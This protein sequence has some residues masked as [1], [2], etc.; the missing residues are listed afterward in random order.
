MSKQTKQTFLYGAT[1]LMAS[2]IVVKLI[3]YIFKIPLSNI[4]QE[5]GMSYFTAA[6]Q[7]FNTVYA[8]TV[9]GLSAAVARMVAET[10]SKGRYRDA[11][12]ILKISNVIFFILGILGMLITLFSAKGIS[13]F[14]KIPNSY[15][16]I[17][18]LSPALFF[19]CAMASYRGYYEGLSNMI[20][21]AITQIV[22]VVVKLIA[23]LGFS[24][25][26]IAIGK[27]QYLQNGT[28]F[29]MVIDNEENLMSALLPYASAGAVLGVTISTLIGFIYIFIRYKMKGDYITKQ[30]LMESPKAMNTN[31]LFLRLVKI[32]IPVT[33][34]AVVIQLS[35]FIDSITISNRLAYA[36]SKDPEYF[37]NLY[38]HLITDDTPMNVFLYGCF[39]V[40]ISIFNLV[41]AFTNIFG[42]SALPNVTAAWTT[43]NKE[44]I[45]T[46]IES[47]IRVTMLIA[48][49]IGFGI[50]A[51]S[52]GILKLLYPNLQGVLTVGP[53]L[54]STLGFGA[55]LL[56]LVTPMNAIMQGIG[57]V[58][59][60][61]KFMFVGAIL[62]LVLN[63]ILIGIPKIN[64]IGS[65]ISTF[66]C[67]GVILALYINTL[68]KNIRINLNYT[69]IFLKPA[70]CGLFCGISAFFSNKA[71]TFMKKDSIITLLSIMVG[72]LV[73]MVSLIALNAIAEDDVLMLPK[74]NK[75]L[76]LF[77]KFRIIR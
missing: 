18:M 5:T 59:L 42:K 76:K 7:L 54:L 68:R 74:G 66:V 12:K 73:Y 43:K 3:G 4:L 39:G 46:N 8:L 27:Q 58:D 71:L 53:A 31:V 21:T 40:V 28:A 25:L 22:E 57:K 51:L 11:R 35:A 13:S 33:L 26:I 9:T 55:I 67:Y 17:V 36:Y 49:P 44:K 75:I 47:V 69:G 41:P 10:T 32:S 29:G 16:S 72:A 23:G 15:W 52:D 56:S 61:V 24:A 48:A 60:P 77:K 6:Y 50:I 62:K 1:I 45:K 19:C 37:L 63:I 2:M 65:S 30:Q 70:I 38:G 34:G 20:P 64:L 14:L